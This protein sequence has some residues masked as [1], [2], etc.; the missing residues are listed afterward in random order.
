[1]SIF[2]QYRLAYSPVIVSCMWAHRVFQHWRGLAPVWEI[3]FAEWWM[4]LHQCVINHLFPC[5]ITPNVSRFYH[6]SVIGL[7]AE[8]LLVEKY[9]LRTYLILYLPIFIW[10]S[11]AVFLWEWM[12]IC[13]WKEWKYVFV[14]SLPDQPI[15]TVHVFLTKQS[16]C[17]NERWPPTAQHRVF[18]H[19]VCTTLGAGIQM[20][21]DLSQPTCPG[22][23][24]H[25]QHSDV[26]SQNTLWPHKH[27]P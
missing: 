20:S 2:V 26:C 11:F 4:H 13:I 24:H 18:L 3:A 9:C 12:K 5:C 27:V 6:L 10:F 23:A 19:C 8:I 25:C 1:M 15:N 16:S 21:F 17:E 7:P 14:N 22:L